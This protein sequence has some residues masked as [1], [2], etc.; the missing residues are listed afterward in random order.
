MNSIEDRLVRD[1]AAVTKGVVMTE[2]DLLYARDAIDERV[3]TGRRRDRRRTVALVAAAALVVAGAGVAAFQLAGGDERTVVPADSRP[4]VDDPHADF[5]SGVPPTVELID[6]FWRLDNGGISMLFDEDGTVQIDDRGAVI[7][8]PATTGTYV[9]EGDTI[10]VTVTEG[11][12][13]NGHEFWMR[14][15]LPKPGHMRVIRSSEGSSECSGIPLGNLVW[16]HVLPTSPEFA[17]FRLSGEPRWKPVTDEATLLGDRFAEGG[18]HILELAPG[19]S[20]YILG[21][22]AEP[23]DQGQWALRAADLVLTSSAA[24]TEC[25]EGDKLVLGDVAYGSGGMAIRGSVQQNT[26]GGAWTPKAWILVPNS[27]NFP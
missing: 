1:I 21:D 27:A 24:S 22:D 4:T 5:F 11:G 19:G 14:A 10:A 8:D 12:T 25:S 15:S 17:R 18:G 6:G 26:C 16:E 20:Y 13:C 2:K 3:A 9:I 7:S 23:V